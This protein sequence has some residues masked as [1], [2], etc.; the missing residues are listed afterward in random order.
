MQL[1]GDTIFNE[2]TLRGCKQYFGVN[3]ST[4]R[5]NKMVGFTN[6]DLDLRCFLIFEYFVGKGFS[7]HDQSPFIM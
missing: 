6:I 1:L 7:N 3:K 5:N 2:N 4:S